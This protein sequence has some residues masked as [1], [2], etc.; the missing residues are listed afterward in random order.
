MQT[1]TIYRRTYPIDGAPVNLSFRSY[2]T[3]QRCTFMVGNKVYEAVFQ[4]ITVAVPE[5]AVVHE[6]KNLLTWIGKTGK[7]QSTAAEVLGFVEAGASG[8]RQLS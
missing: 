6:E 8:F 1:I 3:H 4:Q 5:D 2:P 7:M